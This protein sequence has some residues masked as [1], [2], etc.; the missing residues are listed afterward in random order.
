MGRGRALLLLREGKDSP[1]DALLA[2]PP[3]FW[4][5]ALEMIEIKGEHLRWGTSSSKRN[6]TERFLEKIYSFHEVSATAIIHH[7]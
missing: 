1:R 5:G 3:A 7:S 2:L 4:L 6:E